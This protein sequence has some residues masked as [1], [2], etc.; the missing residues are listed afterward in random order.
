MELTLTELRGIMRGCVGVD[1]TVDLDQDISQTAF[2]DLGYDSLAVLE[3]ASQVENDYGVF[4]PDDV[5]GELDCPA[6]LL[7]FVNDQLAMAS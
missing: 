4:I 2:T 6:S 1:E 5:A 3:M 7:R